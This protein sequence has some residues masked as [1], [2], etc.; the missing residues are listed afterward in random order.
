MPILAVPWNI[1]PARNRRASNKALER[2]SVSMF[3]PFWTW[4][5]AKLDYHGMLSPAGWF[6]KN[7]FVQKTFT[8]KHVFP[9]FSL[10]S[11]ASSVHVMSFSKFSVSSKDSWSLQISIL[12]ITSVSVW[13]EV[14]G[15]ISKSWEVWHL[16]D[17]WEMHL[18]WMVYCH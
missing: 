7:E 17:W 16:S 11:I 12:G 10:M 4:I 2:D 1:T 5:S 6:Y 18:Q 3:R 15:C 9:Y 8:K 14:F 13:Q